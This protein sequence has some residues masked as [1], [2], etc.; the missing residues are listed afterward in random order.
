[1]EAL[2]CK[3]GVN[4]AKNKGMRSLLVETDSQE[5][6]KAWGMPNFQRLCISSIIRE[7]KELSSVFF[8]NFSLVYTN[9]SCNQ[10]AHVLAKQAS[11]D[12]KMGEW[13][14]APLVF[15]IC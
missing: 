7:T 14:I 4:L 9:R 15:L 10:V 8:C 12:N 2:T 6:V 1:M 11:D 3:D 5:L 13:Q